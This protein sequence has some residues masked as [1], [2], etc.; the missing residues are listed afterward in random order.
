MRKS[1]VIKTVLFLYNNAETEN[2]GY[3]INVD[4]IFEVTDTY[5]DKR[6]IYAKIGM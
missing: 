2:D 5:T 3:L 4:R 1:I 6:Q